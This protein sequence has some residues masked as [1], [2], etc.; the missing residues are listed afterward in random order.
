MDT[1]AEKLRIYGGLARHVARMLNADL[2]FT[3]TTDADEAVRDADYIITT[4][5]VGGD[6][7]RVRDERIALDLGI[8]GQETTGAAGLSFAMYASSRLPYHFSKHARQLSKSPS[9]SIVD[10]SAVILRLM[11]SM[12]SPRVT[13]AFRIF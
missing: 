2:T 5:R 4:I 10:S 13:P 3:L 9:M 8:L 12:T 7:T 1:D 6:H 11:S